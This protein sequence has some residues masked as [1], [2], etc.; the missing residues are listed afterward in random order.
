M[1][2]HF[3]CGFAALCL[4]VKAGLTSVGD[5]PHCIGL[6]GKETSTASAMFHSGS[7]VGPGSEDR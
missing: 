7:A 4:C 2:R 3:G 6:W 1:F 5:L